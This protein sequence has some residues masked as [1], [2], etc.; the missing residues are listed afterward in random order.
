[1]SP[2]QPRPL[3]TASNAPCLAF[4][5]PAVM[6]G[7]YRARGRFH[8]RLGFS[9]SGGRC[10]RTG[11]G[12]PVRR[13]PARGAVEARSD[14]TFGRTSAATDLCVD[15]TWCVP[16]SVSLDRCHRSLTRSPLYSRDTATVGL[17]TGE[18]VPPVVVPMDRFSFSDSGGRC[19][20]CREWPPDSTTASMRYS[21]A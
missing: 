8:V 18:I 14:S 1:M 19:G 16:A 6:A 15:R 20:S 3:L 13:L 4:R 12:R 10:A 2:C 9:D 11:N 7:W 21:E 17:D 5:T